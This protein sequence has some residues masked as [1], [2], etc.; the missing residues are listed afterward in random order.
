M[1]GQSVGSA[2][3]RSPRR[4]APV[5]ST[6]ERCLATASILL[7]SLPAQ[8][9]LQRRLEPEFCGVQRLADGSLAKDADHRVRTDAGRPV[10]LP[11]HHRAQKIE[12]VQAT[13]DAVAQNLLD[14]E[15]PRRA[16]LVG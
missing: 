11:I 7:A 6:S 3:A 8:R 5:I 10:R 12:L 2:G 16:F 9:L 13:T 1:D 15:L 4:L 14:H